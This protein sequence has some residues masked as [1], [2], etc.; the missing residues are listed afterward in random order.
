LTFAHR[1]DCLR[2]EGDGRHAATT[3]SS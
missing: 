3:G 2:L 1:N